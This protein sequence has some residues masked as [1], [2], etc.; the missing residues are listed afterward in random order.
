ML[1]ISLGKLV[2]GIEDPDR[3]EIEAN[4]YITFIDMT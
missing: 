1:K 2:F 4:G 3:V